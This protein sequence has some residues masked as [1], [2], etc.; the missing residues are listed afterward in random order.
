MSMVNSIEVNRAVMEGVGEGEEVL[1]GK[2]PEGVVES[3]AKSVWRWARVRI[4]GEESGGYFINVEWSR[5]R[6][7]VNH[8]RGI[9]ILKQEVPICGYRAAK[10]G[11]VEIEKDCLLGGV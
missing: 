1:L 5:E 8:R 4:H 2:V 3:G 9:Q 6:L 11:G 10:E 7:V